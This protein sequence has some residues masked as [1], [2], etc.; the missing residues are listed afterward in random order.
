[1]SKITAKGEDLNITVEEKDGNIT[2]FFNGLED[3]FLLSS[4]NEMVD[5]Q[6]PMGGTYYPEPGTMMAY[7]NVLKHGDFFS[8]IDTVNVEGDIGELPFEPG[9]IY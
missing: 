2:V 7:Y 6:P 8:W 5:N 1:M 4:L 3:E 9:I